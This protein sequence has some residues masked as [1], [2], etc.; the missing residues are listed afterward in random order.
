MSDSKRPANPEAEEQQWQM[1]LLESRARIEKL[2]LD[3]EYLKRQI[4]LYPI[5]IGSGVFLALVAFAKLFI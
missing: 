2:E 3:A 1:D 5:V 4:T